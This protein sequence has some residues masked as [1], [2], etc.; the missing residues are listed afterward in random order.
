MSLEA[1]G[2]VVVGGV[3]SWALT[4][5]RDNETANRSY[6]TRRLSSSREAHQYLDRFVNAHNTILMPLSEFADGNI[7]APSLVSVLKA[8]GEE[9]NADDR[10]I[11]QLAQIVRIEF[12]FLQAHLDR[13]VEVRSTIW[14]MIDLVPSEAVSVRHGPNLVLQRKVNAAKSALSEAE[15]E[16]S[17]ELVRIAKAYSAPDAFTMNKSRQPDFVLGI[18]RVDFPK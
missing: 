9:V 3:L 10:S 8:S 15:Y 7:T 18:R 12:P 16:L 11:S 5:W 4:W 17:A 6:V 1:I 2:G 13:L 14:Q